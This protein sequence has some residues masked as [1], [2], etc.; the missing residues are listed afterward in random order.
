[1]KPCSIY[2][3]IINAPMVIVPMQMSRQ[4]RYSANRV[5]NMKRVF[6][7]MIKS[8]ERTCQHISTR[9][10]TRSCVTRSSSASNIEND[11]SPDIIIGRFIRPCNWV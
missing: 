5:N 3:G 9:W 4:S 7:G 11:H 2:S 1:M 10:L 6:L 8:T